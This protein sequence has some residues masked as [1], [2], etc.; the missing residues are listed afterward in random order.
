MLCSLF[1]LV[2]GVAPLESAP[3]PSEIILASLDLYMS[4]IEFLFS[5]ASCFLLNYSAYSAPMTVKAS[6]LA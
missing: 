6:L 2:M 5:K 3:L 4:S 1:L